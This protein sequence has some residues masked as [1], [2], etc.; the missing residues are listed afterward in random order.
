MHKFMHITTVQARPGCPDM[1][2]LPARA[3]IA[4]IANMTNAE[5]WQC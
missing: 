4:K 5:G 3:P 1:P 2:A